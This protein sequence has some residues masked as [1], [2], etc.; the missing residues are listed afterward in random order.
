MSLLTGLWDFA[1]EN[2]SYAAPLAL[3]IQRMEHRMDT[4]NVVNDIFC[5]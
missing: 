2:Y 4:S 5:I 1:V 3:R